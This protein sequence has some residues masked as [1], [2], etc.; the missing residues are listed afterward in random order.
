M[1]APVVGGLR[2]AATACGASRS[3]EPGSRRTTHGPWRAGS[4]LAVRAGGH[5][6]GGAGDHAP[7][8]AAVGRGPGPPPP[9]AGLRLGS[10]LEGDPAAAG[11]LECGLQALLDDLRARSHNP[12]LELEEALDRRCPGLGS[13]LRRAWPDPQ[14]QPGGGAGLLRPARPPRRRPAQPGCRRGGGGAAGRDRAAR[15]PGAAGACGAARAGGAAAGLGTIGWSSP[16]RLEQ[17]WS[18]AGERHGRWD[19]AGSGDGGADGGRG[20]RS[21]AQGRQAAPERQK[22]EAL[23]ILELSWGLPGRGEGGSPPPGEAPPPGHGGDAEAFRRI[24]AAYQV[25]IA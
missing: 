25:L 13:E 22:V 5:H 14:P 24:N 12:A 3:A 20:E 23:A 21:S 15:V 9:L 6:R 18:G 10:R 19:G 4:L 17:G 16:G 7:A 11:S 2:A 8:G 1:P